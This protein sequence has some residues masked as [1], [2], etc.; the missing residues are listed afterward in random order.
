VKG[1][2]G[3]FGLTAMAG[4]LLFGATMEALAGITLLF[5]VAFSIRFGG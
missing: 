4:F 3:N 5:R 1:G 2:T